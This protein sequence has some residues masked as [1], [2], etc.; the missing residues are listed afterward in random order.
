M[1]ICP[2]CQH[3]NIDGTQFCE[4]CGEE[5]PQATTAAS[6]EEL[7]ACPECGH[8]NPSDNI[9]CEACGAELQSV[10][11]ATPAAAVAATD[12]FAGLPDT[13]L[14]PPLSATPFEETTPFD[15]LAKP[16]DP[17]PAPAAVA[18]TEPAPA[19]NLTPGSVKLVVE[20]GQTVGAQF[21]LGDPELLVGREDEDEEIYPDIDL[22]DQDAGYVHRKH[23]TITFEN[24][25][26]FV[27]HLGGSNKTRINNKPVG[28]NV[29][30]PFNLGDKIAFGKVV[31][32]LL[33]A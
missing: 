26:L 30:T 29:A 22:S 8:E 24:G 5:L 31:L 3:E 19:G 27:T 2:A 7:I 14:A 18:T 11:T 6:S 20:Q 1:I 12:P 32:R 4:M 9:A 15:T 21:V 23:A 25:N 16:A 13:G 17:A 28:D 10:S 33:P